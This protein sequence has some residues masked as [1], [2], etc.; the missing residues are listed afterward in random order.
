MASAE[1]AEIT[2][3]LAS[4]FNPNRVNSELAD[5]SPDPEIQLLVDAI[6]KSPRSISELRT[7]P[8]FSRLT[9]RQLTFLRAFA[10]T[11]RL[12]IAC[13]SAGVSRKA[14]GSWRRRNPE[15]A[16]A[17]QAA[18]WTAVRRLESAAFERVFGPESSS[19]ELLMFMLRRLDQM[20]ERSAP[21]GEQER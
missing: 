3:M 1:T 4:A 19:D 2:Q 5:F 20:A 10:Y 9:V 15:F 14:P 21:D 18:V 12:G 16:T 11:G 7:V 8:N 13:E 6:W 17:Y